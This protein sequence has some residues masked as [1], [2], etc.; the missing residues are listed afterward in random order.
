MAEKNAKAQEAVAEA[1]TEDEKL[2]AMSET[3]CNKDE[4]KIGLVGHVID[5]TFRV[6]AVLQRDGVK[7]RLETDQGTSFLDFSHQLFLHL[8]RND[9]CATQIG[10][11][12]QW[13]NIASRIELVR[14]SEVSCVAV[15][16]HQ[17]DELRDIVA[18][19]DEAPEKC[20]AEKVLTEMTEMTDMT[21]MMHGKEGWEYMV[22][23]KH[24]VYGDMS[25]DEDKFHEDKFQ[26]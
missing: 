21:E 13:G 11:S 16:R 2:A 18:E 19:H 20:A 12:D 14:N 10:G 9:G 5:R 17:V 3:Q 25:E 8:Y 22:D 24:G 7:K 1:A 23:D 15:F 26:E 6:N 4:L